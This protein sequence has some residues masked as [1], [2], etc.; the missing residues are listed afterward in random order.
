M[1]KF[2]SSFMDG[3]ADEGVSP[4]EVSAF[5]RT[6]VIVEEVGPQDLSQD[7]ISKLL[8]FDKNGNGKIDSEG[9][10]DAFCEL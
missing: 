5:L 1:V 4:D 6:P 8:K 9:E 7:D 2:I 10:I 3:N